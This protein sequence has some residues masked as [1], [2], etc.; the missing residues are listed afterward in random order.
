MRIGI[1][2][3]YVGVREGGNERYCESIIRCLGANGAPD[4]EYFVFSYQ[5]AAR[6]RLANDRLTHLPLR[7]RSV[8]WQR[9]VELPLYSRRLDLDVLHV[10]FNFLPVSRCRKIVTI[11]DLGFLH[12]PSTY[13]VAERM[14]MRLMTRHAALEAD[15]VLTVSEFAKQDIIERYGISP[16]RVTV[17]PNAVDRGIFRRFSEDETEAFRQR[18]G[19]PS[20]YFL[21]VGV[22]Q[23]RKNVAA[24]IDAYARL[25]SS[26][27]TD[28]QL[29]LVGRLGRM[30][31][32][33][34]RLIAARALDRLVHRFDEVDATVL[35]GFYNAAAALVVPSRWE[36][37]SIPV[38][39]AM[40]C[41][42]PVIC[43]Q[44][45]GMPEVCGDAA[46]PFDPDDPEELVAHLQRI[47][48]DPTLRSDLVRRGLVNCDRFSWERT[49]R[50]VQSVYEAA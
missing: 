49:A 8:L 14:R 48:D 28:H 46:L 15:H 32:A 33:V 5:G 47:V 4:H 9:G 25:P 2:A 23:Q 40:S 36:S 43:S 27:R 7:S 45:A 50:L 38:L 37:F 39:E 1:D 29:V 16:S 31:E 42:C 6:R 35:A 13:G 30:H 18:L 10:P 34:L 21:F 26:A 22:I 44:A 11:H 41:G 17:T 3:H 19:L 24:L 12:V 20:G